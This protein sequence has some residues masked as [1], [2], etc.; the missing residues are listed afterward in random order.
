MK[1]IDTNSVKFN[2]NI[3]LVLKVNKSG[4]DQRN[5]YEWVEKH[6]FTI[7]A[8]TKDE[9]VKKILKPSVRCM[10]SDGRIPEYAFNDLMM[11]FR[12]MICNRY[13]IKNADDFGGIDVYFEPTVDEIDF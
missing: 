7:K 10:Y 11:K 3:V 5:D 6:F 8:T 9:L 1:N 2:N 4:G 12:T 13:G